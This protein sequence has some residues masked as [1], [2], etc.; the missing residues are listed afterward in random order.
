M[1]ATSEATL[2]R[3]SSALNF[4][5]WEFGR[6]EKALDMRRKM[7]RAPSST[8]QRAPVPDSGPWDGEPDK[9]QW[10]DPVTDFD[11]LVLRNHMGSWCGYVGLPPGHSLHGK[12]YEKADVEVHGGLT[13]ASFCDPDEGDDKICHVPA[14]GRPDEVWWLGFDCAHYMDLTPGMISF[15]NEPSATYRDLEYVVNEVEQL[16]LQLKS[17]RA[18]V[19]YRD[20]DL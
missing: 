13:F 3:L 9:V 19:N 18:V 15:I 5:T 10:V 7:R 4:Q 8:F 6:L 1:N 17:A 14:P 11:C 2:E 20:S 12:D 16:A